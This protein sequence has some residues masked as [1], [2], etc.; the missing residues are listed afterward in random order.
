LLRS[1]IVIVITRNLKTMKSVSYWGLVLGVGLSAF[2]FGEFYVS[3]QQVPSHVAPMMPRSMQAG[4]GDPGTVPATGGSGDDSMY[5]GSDGS[6]SD[7]GG[8]M[9]SDD[10]AY[11][12]DD[13]GSMSSDDG[14]YY[15]DDGGSMYSDDGS[16]YSDDGGSMYSDD[17]AYYSDDGGSMYSDDGGSMHSE[18]DGAYNSDDGMHHSDDGMHHSDD[19]SMPP[20]DDASMGSGP[21]RDESSGA[22]STVGR[23]ENSPSAAVAA[24]PGCDRDMCQKYDQCPAKRKLLS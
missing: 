19:G 24:A 15:S 4:S 2:G 11:Y 21:V 8:S 3:G 10:G 12:S 16:Y 6:Y 14:A 5:A 9:Y 18:D 23:G 20:Q 22:A 1:E 17:G 7:D 13:G